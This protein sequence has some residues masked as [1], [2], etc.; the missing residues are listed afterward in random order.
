MFHR[1][2]RFLP[3]TLV[4]TVAACSSDLT[5]PSVAFDRPSMA[6]S[7]AA[8]AETQVARIAIPAGTSQ[9]LPC[10]NNGD[11]ETVDVSGATMMKLHINGSPVSG[12]ANALIQWKADGVRMVGRTTG[13]V[14]RSSTSESLH[15]NFQQDPI[16]G[17]RT[18]S[19]DLKAQITGQGLGR[20]AYAFVRLRGPQR[21]SGLP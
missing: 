13:I 1:A 7:N 14:Y 21:R 9:F 16:S 12:Q 17:L 10:V 11:G 8:D 3:L 19:I 15:L 2:F 6:S 18:G 20:A 5:S 4:A